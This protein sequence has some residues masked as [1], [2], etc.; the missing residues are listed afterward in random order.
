MRQALLTVLSFVPVALALVW[1]LL[2][3]IEVRRIRR[4]L[5]ETVGSPSFEQEHCFSEVADV[6]R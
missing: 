6:Q 4:L 2:L 5:E 3:F 1:A